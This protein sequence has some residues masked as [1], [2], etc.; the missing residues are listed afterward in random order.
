MTIM[1]NHSSATARTKSPHLTNRT[2]SL[3]LKRRA[4]SI[5]NNKSIDAGPRAVIRC[6]LEINDPLLPQLVRRTEAGEI[7]I[8]N[9]NPPTPQSSQ[10]YSDATDSVKDHSV[11]YD[12]VEEHSGEDDSADYR[13]DWNSSGE[14]HTDE[15][16]SIEDHSVEDESV[17]AKLK[18]KI[19]TL[20]FL[21][22]RAGDEPETKSAALLVLMS[23]LENT[24]HPKSVTNIAKHLAFTRCC[25]LNFHGMLDTQLAMVE[26]EL[27]ASHTLI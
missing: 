21:I 18:A 9:L 26:R 24:R 25:D 7:I 6:G 2:I 23:T 17:P 10:N 16:D 1:A 22:C 19:E 12:S 13:L 14:D 20:T 8:D 4:Q 27:V 11:E 5:I 3:A 15:N